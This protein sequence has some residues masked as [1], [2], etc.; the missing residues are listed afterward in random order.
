[1]DLSLPYNRLH[2]PITLDWA[3]HIDMAP[4]KDLIQKAWLALSSEHNEYFGHW[5][6]NA[7]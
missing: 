6:C 4:Q 3:A 7:T 5:I 2:Q 1:M